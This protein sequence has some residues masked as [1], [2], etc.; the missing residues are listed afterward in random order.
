[1]L[2]QGLLEYWLTFLACARVKDVLVLAQD[3]I[4]QVEALVGA[5]VRWGLNVEV[6]ATSRELTA[7]E[8]LA[9]YG[10]EWTANVLD[11]FPELPDNP[12]FT[13]YRDWFAAL[14]AWMPRARTPDRAGVREVQPGVWIGLHGNV[15]QQAELRAPCWLGDHVYVGPGA[16]IGPGSIL[17]SGAFVEPDA[18]VG[19]SLRFLG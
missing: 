10:P 16:V 8:A 2:G 15:S 11:H 18:E 12:L 3:R 19:E 4:D 17:E 5:G 7:E 9:K 13:S 6:A 14:Q 1:M